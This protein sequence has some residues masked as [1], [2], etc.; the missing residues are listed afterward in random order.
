MVRDR[1]FREDLYFRLSSLTIQLLPL[2]ERPKTRR[3][4]RAGSSSATGRRR[5]GG[6]P[7]ALRRFAEHPW[8]GN[9]REL[10]NVLRAWPF[11]DGDEIAPTTS[12]ASPELV[13]ARP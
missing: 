10:E 6:S 4:W 5:P 2:R 13:R 1:T 9:V 3:C 12:R 7:A 8:P 11:A